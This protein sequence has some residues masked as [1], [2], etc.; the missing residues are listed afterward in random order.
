MTS[1]LTGQVPTAP[2]DYASRDRRRRVLQLPA[3]CAVDLERCCGPLHAR[4]ARA[5]VCSYCCCCCQYQESDDDFVLRLPTEEGLA[6]RFEQCDGVEQM[7][8]FADTSCSSTLEDASSAVGGAIR[9]HGASA[10]EK[11]DSIQYL[12]A[13]RTLGVAVVT[14]L[15]DDYKAKRSVTVSVPTKFPIGGRNAQ[16][17]SC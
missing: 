6:W 11:S 12:E 16:A 3:A 17:V 10:V 1:P 2:S 15:S 4:C 7:V 5:R 9:Y 8:L 13:S 14:V